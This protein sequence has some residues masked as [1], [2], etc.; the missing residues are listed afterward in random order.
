M[1]THAAAAHHGF[2]HDAVCYGSD[3][4]L[5]AV[6]VPFLLEGLEAGQP[7][8]VAL[9]ERN[10]E[11]IR[12][13]MPATEQLSFVPPS[14][15]YTRPAS[16]IETYRRML[17]GHVAAGA[18]RI[19]IVGEV[20]AS[21]CGMAWQWWARYEAAINYAYQEFPLWAMCAYDTRLTTPQVLDD[22][23][24]TH[25]FLVDGDGRRVVNDRFTDP[26]AFLTEPRS[27]IA[28]PLESSPPISELVN[29]TPTVARRAV[30]D[31]SRG[32][33]LPT[34]DV[35]DLVIAVSETV[36]NAICHGHPPV[37]LRIWP[38]P[39]RIVVTVTDEGG[40]PTDPFA[41]LLPA[42]SAP[43]GGL[44]LW[45]T[46]QLCELVTIDRGERG[47]TIRLVAGKPSPA[48]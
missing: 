4:Q 16:T 37:Q 7:T 36:T 3:K 23:A 39:D 41:G 9:R 46:Y 20:P 6:V 27:S 18:Q 24:R 28:D 33:R 43:V 47:C 11:L 1:R 10:A 40:G 48:S 17:A 2:A 8:R 44:G 35:E 19:R 26:V 45:V 25:Q 12:S 42:A 31:A 14:A 30:L 21:E 32:T 38:G 29:P 5:L 22:V 13:V 34:A 15:V